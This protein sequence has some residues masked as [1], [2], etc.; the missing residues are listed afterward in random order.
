MH[1]PK[2]GQQQ[3]VQEIKFCSRCGFPLGLVTEIV[4][5]GGFLPQLADLH[6]SKKW[7][8][9][10]NGILFSILWSIFFVCIMTPMWGVMG[11]EALAAVS[12]V[13]GIFGG[14]MILITTMMT[15]KKEP[16]PNFASFGQMPN[17]LPNQ[18]HQPLNSAAN[19]YLPPPSAQSFDSY[20]SPTSAAGWRAQDTDDLVKRDSVT[21]NTTKLL[22][23][24]E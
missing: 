15:L 4:A 9:R 5:H 11:V 16:D 17:Q 10:R 1:C 3:A 19:A 21:D 13:I 23:R 8:T 18:Q 24:D 2:C 12:S 14:L 7:L 6:K 20:A 22:Q